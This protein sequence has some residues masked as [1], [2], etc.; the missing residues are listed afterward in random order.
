MP[1]W[2][3]L[4][5]LFANVHIAYMFEQIVVSHFS[6]SSVERSKSISEDVVKYLMKVAQ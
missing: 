3:S 4:M 5:Y 2:W 6:F 1:L